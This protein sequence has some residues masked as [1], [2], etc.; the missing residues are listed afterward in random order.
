MVLALNVCSAQPV[1]NEHWT[2]IR[3][4]RLFDGKSDRMLR[5]QFIIIKGAQ[6]AEL[7]AAA[8]LCIPAGSN[9]IDLSRATVLPGLIDAHTRVFENCPDLTL[10]S[11]RDCW[12]CRT[13]AALANAQKDLLASFTTVQF[14]MTPLQAILLS[15]AEAAKLI[16]GRI[17]SDS[18]E[19]G[20]FPDLVSV[21]GDPARNV[22]ELQR[23]KF[24]MKGGDVV[25]NEYQTEC[26][27]KKRFLK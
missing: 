23:V 19:P 1:S 6:I 21:S 7:G 13:L 4:R 12:Q 2:A 20:N 26:H 8:Q 11:L 14:G 3:A 15:T 16:D 22:T 27:E 9:V 24:V 18:G 25:R 17:A 5:D 10:Q